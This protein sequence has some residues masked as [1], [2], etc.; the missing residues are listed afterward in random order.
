[1][2]PVFPQQE[3]GVGARDEELQ[4]AFLCFVSV[5]VDLV[6][7]LGRLVLFGVV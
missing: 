7:L 2:V 3:A 4:G 5:Y 6:W 1:V